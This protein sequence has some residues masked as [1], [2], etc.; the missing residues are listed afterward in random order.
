[1]LAEA[2]YDRLDN[3]IDQRLDPSTGMEQY[4]NIN[5]S[6]GKGLEFEV[7]AQHNR[8]RGE[9]SY[10][11]QRSIDRNS[12]EALDNSPL[13]LAKL[14]MQAPLRSALLAGVE[15]HYHSP[16]TTYLDSRIRDFLT[17]NL[18]MSTAKPIAGFDLSASCYNL[19]DRRNYDPVSPSLTELRLLQDGRGIRVKVSRT[20]SRR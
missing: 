19:F 13:H 4:V 9:L 20:I 3:L 5:S 15:L 18:T 11:L 16:Q 12:G 8:W 7:D 2:Y 14:K 17:T 6:S 1:M 10:T